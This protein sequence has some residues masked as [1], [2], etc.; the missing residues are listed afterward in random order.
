MRVTILAV[1]TCSLLNVP[2]ADTVKLS[3]TT[4]PVLIARVVSIAAVL[5]PSYSLLDAVMPEIVNAL[6]L[7]VTVFC[8][9]PK[10]LLRAAVI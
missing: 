5:L 1:P 3:P 2:V 6:A 9:L 10:V 4:R 8:V 7:N